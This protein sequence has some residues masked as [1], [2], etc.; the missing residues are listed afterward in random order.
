MDGPSSE[1]LDEIERKYSHGIAS[2]D[3]VALLEQHGCKISEATLRKYVQV[4]LLP[5]SIRVGRKGKHRGSQGL[6]PASIVRQI[7]EI[8]QLL[9]DGRTIEEIKNEYF[10][11][12][13]E[14]ETVEQ[15]TEKLFERVEIALES[16]LE[17]AT[18]EAVTRELKTART[19]AETLLEKLRNIEA[20]LARRAQL[21]RN[22]A[23]TG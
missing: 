22:A 4:G 16:P 5:R 11:L 20:R 3:I 10:L 21:T 14:I 9:N 8:K 1:V 15:G 6:Y 7:I 18:V 17:E 23:Q 13:S 12:R 19:A 2:T